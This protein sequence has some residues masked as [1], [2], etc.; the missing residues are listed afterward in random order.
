M[1][2]CTLSIGGTELE[3]EALDGRSAL[4]E[5]FRF[6]L[7]AALPE[8]GAAPV[9][10]LGGEARLTLRDPL[11]G[12]VT[13]TG[14]AT[15]VGRRLSP[16]GTGHLELTLEPELALL[17]VGQNSRVL[18]DLDVIGIGKKVL[19]DAGIDAAH[20]RWSATGSYPQRV[21]C[22]QYRESDLAFLL[23]LLAEEG[24]YL[25][26]EHGD[27]GTIA[28]FSDDST[29][30]PPLDGDP[31]VVQRDEASLGAAADAVSLVRRRARLAV[32][33]TRLRDYDFQK[34]KLSLDAKSGSGAREVYDFP[35]RFTAPPVG[36]QRA[37]RL[38]ESLRARRVVISGS[39]SMARLRTG[40][41]FELAETR[42]A[43]LEGRYLVDEVTWRS[44][45]GA[46][47]WGL[48]QAWTAIPI[49]VPFR[50]ERADVVRRPGGPQ[51][52][53]VVG[54]AGD[55][56][57]PDEMGRV[58]VQHYWDREG[59][60]DDKASTWMRVG[61]F[62]T[63]GSMVI[64][65][66]GWDVVVHHHDGDIDQPMVLSHLYDG[67]FP[68]PYAL[69]ANK[70]RT[71]WQ[72]A[73][74]PGG[75]SSNEIR[76]EDKA[77]SEEIFINAS[78]DMNVVI[79]D[80]KGEKVGV[81]HTHDIGANLTHKVGSAY[82]LAVTSNR[83]M[84]IGASET[85][86]VS[87]GREVSIGGSAT[88]S[89][90][91]S[92][93]ATISSGSTLEAK[94]GRS[95]TVGG[96]MLTAAGLGVNRALLGTLSVSIGGSWI[97]AAAAG[98]S[99]MTGGACAET[100]GGAKIAAGATGTVT[101]VKGAL[102]ET[103]GGAYVIAAGAKA[104]EGATG[105]LAITVGGAFLANAPSIE[106]EADSEISILCGGASIKITAGSIEVKAPTLASP[107]AIIAKKAGKI[108]HN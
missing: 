99:A 59:Q 78:K 106:A 95:L 10:L 25:W 86:T 21:Y 63:G 66:L 70:T 98:V 5:L 47:G 74:T 93:T 69:P 23:R 27:D 48:R 1:L 77:G 15:S 89:I 17:G 58:R 101:G 7:Q 28:V 94:A 37:A 81:D 12:Q 51:T 61:Q 54:A 92:R 13:I 42:P 20:T 65:R 19:E 26:F 62:A 35:G 53:V 79:G 90:G 34:P 102:A 32:E 50:P 24:L 85:L 73:T 100:I 46:D 3:V 40:L 84:T 52:G 41:S 96:T 38:L 6:T 71:A 36:S 64:P 11:A 30:A 76:F 49:D 39:A 104:S 56:I 9:D 14:I 18:R 57:H 67:R 75:G 82:K 68:V 105:S 103:V 107:G 43:S 29:T 97:K 4:G 31:R 60:R 2:S 16:D 87:G 83:D 80:N 44:D 72:T 88:I 55:E 45:R 91:G 33:A 8:A 22:V 108:Q